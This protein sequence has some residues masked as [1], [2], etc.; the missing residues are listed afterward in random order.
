MINNN[1]FETHQVLV[2]FG[3]NIYLLQ[4]LSIIFLKDGLCVLTF[5]D[6][7]E[8][9]VDYQN[10]LACDND[11]SNYENDNIITITNVSNFFNINN[12]SY[13]IIM[14][15]DEF[16]PLLYTKYRI[17]DNNIE[18]EFTDDSICTMPISNVLL[19]EKQE[20]IKALKPKKVT[21]FKLKMVNE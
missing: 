2:R 14:D 1:S 21:N 8:L 6:G 9:K 11:I 5:A 12:G 19:Y 17:E 7:L 20:L 16:Y 4:V 15:K 18:L 10:F 3:R 13:A